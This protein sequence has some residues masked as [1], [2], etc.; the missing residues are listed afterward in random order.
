MNVNRTYLELGS[1]RVEKLGRGIAWLDIRTHQTLM[2]PANF[3]ETIEERQVVKVT[4]IE[5]IANR[6]EYLD[7][8]QLT[9]LTEVKM[10]NNHGHYP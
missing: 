3:I 8:G 9:N 5:V 2:Q 4:C 7:G 6:M 10:N 1:L